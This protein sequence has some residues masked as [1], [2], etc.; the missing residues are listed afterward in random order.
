MK[1]F[2]VAS[3]V[4]FEPSW[5]EPEINAQRMCDFIDEAVKDKLVDLVVFPE[6]SNLGY[7]T[8][9]DKKFSQKYMSLAET[10]DGPTA[11]I[12]REK[13]KERGVYAIV[14]MTLKSKNL[15]G[16]VFNSALL[17][18]PNGTIEGVYNKTHIA[19]EEKHYFVP[20][21]SLP[22]FETDIGKIGIMICYDSLFPEVAR[23]LTLKGADI[24]VAIF[25]S[26]MMDEYLHNR[27]A[28]LA[29]VRAWENKNFVICCNRVG[30]QAGW[31]WLGHSAISSAAGKVLAYSDSEAE[32]IITASFESKQILEE[33]AYLTTFRDRRPDLYGEITEPITHAIDSQFAE[34][35]N[36][37]S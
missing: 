27:Y 33:R 7:V 28:H 12:L 10:L 17:F 9:R 37:L 29:S 24:L 35:R 11:T 18:G 34:L 19:A 8:G 3:A 25:N 30:E 26:P 5:L 21:N 13:C 2:V 22:V 15:P 23:V 16:T 6:L 31:K 20:G 1:E 32:D 14:G 4:Q 36:A